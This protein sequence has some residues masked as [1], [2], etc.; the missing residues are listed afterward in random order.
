MLEMTLT[1]PNKLGLHVRAVSK[2]VHLAARFQSD[3]LIQIG[4]KQVNGKSLMNLLT[5]GAKQGDSVQ[6]I[7]NG[8][9]EQE[10]MTAITQLIDSRFDEPE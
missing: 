4:T 7:I 6:L 9:D 2:F 3:V 8:L 10:A 5:L 1:I